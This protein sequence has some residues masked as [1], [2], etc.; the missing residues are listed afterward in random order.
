MNLVQLIEAV[1]REH[2]VRLAP[3]DPVLVSVFLTEKVIEALLTS[4]AAQIENAIRSG[5]AEIAAVE[6]D[7]RLR[8]RDEAAML[9][10]DARSTLVEQLKT[11]LAEAAELALARVRE[12]TQGAERMR[13]GARRYAGLAGVCAALTLAAL[14][15]WV[16]AGSHLFG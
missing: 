4:G 7:A 15:G 13:K 14:V 11:T 6:S 8:A 9:I 10:T 3:E 1:R 16:L 2:G 12:E 5:V